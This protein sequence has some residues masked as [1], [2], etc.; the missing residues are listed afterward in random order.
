MA[1]TAG[2]LAD[3]QLPTT[4]GTLLT[5]AASTTGYV[6][7]LFLYNGNAATQTV[8]LYLKRSGSTS[9]QIRRVELAQY[10]SASVIEGEVAILLSTGD[11]IEGDTTTSSAVDYYIAGVLET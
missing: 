5:I 3:G 9:R 8:N 7:N 4:K 1:F 6:K 11:V 2:S 10:E